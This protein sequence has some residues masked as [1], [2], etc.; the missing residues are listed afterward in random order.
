M[1]NLSQNLELDRCPHCTTDTPSLVL[2]HGVGSADHKGDNRRYWGL[3]VCK[4]CGGV[5]VCSSRHP[6]GAV[7][8]I[9]PNVMSV[10]EVIPEKPRAYLLQALE[11]LHAP[12]GAIMLAA[13]SVDAMLKEKGYVDGSLYSRIDEA[14]GKHLITQDMSTWAHQVRLEANEER[15]ADDD[16]MMPSYQDAKLTVNFAQA[17]AEFLFVLPSMVTKGLEETSPEEEG[18]DV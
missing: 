3:Y 10:D 13:S 4:R 5:V 8:E 11:C 2:E 9:Y 7:L 1:P 12:S 14:A 16:A 18:K 15:H 6:G 17:L